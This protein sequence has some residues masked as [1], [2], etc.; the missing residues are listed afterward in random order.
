MLVQDLGF[1]QGTSS[2]NIF[3]H[4]QRGITCSVHGDDFTSSG[5]KPSLDWLEA[6]ISKRYEII[7]GP[8]LGPG[9]Q[10]AKEAIVRNRVV[11]WCGDAQ[12]QWLEYEADPQQVE[13]LVAFRLEADDD[14]LSVEVDVR[15]PEAAD[16][17]AEEALGFAAGIES[18]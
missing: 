14:L 12:G 8:R 4:K 11:R 9:P 18:D 1:S 16:L 2:P 10:D 3:H 5:P 17:V 6:A 15:T 7:I 13:R